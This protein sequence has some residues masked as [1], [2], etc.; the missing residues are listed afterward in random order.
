MKI[1]EFENDPSPYYK[2]IFSNRETLSSD[3]TVHLIQSF[4]DL[5]RYFFKSASRN[6]IWNP[7][8]GFPDYV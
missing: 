2:L 7:D 6:Q 1:N 5:T 4:G 8:F 3:T